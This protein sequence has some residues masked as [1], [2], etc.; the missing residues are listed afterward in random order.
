MLYSEEH[1]VKHGTL[2]TNEQF[3]SGG[4]KKNQLTIIQCDN[5][6]IYLAYQI[7]IKTSRQDQSFLRLSGVSYRGGNVLTG[8]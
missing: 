5:Y 3:R 2:A 7:M 6:E 1:K 4:G 8:S